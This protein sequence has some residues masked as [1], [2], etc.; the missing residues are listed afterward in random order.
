MLGAK[1]G[2]FSEKNLYSEKD[3]EHTVC[4]MES[5]TTIEMGRG[6]TYANEKWT[7]YQHGIFPRSSVL[8]GQSRRM[9]IDDFDTLEEAKAAFPEAKVLDGSTYRPPSL[10]H[11]LDDEG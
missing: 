9:W 1:P 11:L 6:A 7:V 2:N 3:S 10:H 5:Y 4:A 8:A